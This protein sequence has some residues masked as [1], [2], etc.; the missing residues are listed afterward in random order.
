MGKKARLNKEALFKLLKYEPH[1]GQMLVHRSRARKRVLACGVRWGKSTLAA[2]EAIAAAMEPRES[3]I[4]WVAAPT[5]DLSKRI[6][7]IIVSTVSAHLSHRIISLKEHEHR[8][9]LLNLGGG[10]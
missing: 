4:G 5:Y 6:F 8:L 10:K 7:D 3:S 9:I 2:M 1:A